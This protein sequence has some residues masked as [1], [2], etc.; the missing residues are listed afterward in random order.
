MSR[1]DTII[2][3]YT[4][5]LVKYKLVVIP[6]PLLRLRTVP[7]KNPAAVAL[8]RLGGKVGGKSRME[9]MSAAQRTEFASRGGKV[10]GKARAQ[11]L[12][13]KRRSE[14]ARKAAVAR[15]AKARGESRK[16]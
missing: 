13:R 12:S 9:Q 6:K 1:L 4:T 2:M 7:K 5:A 14:I 3:H 8:G 15:W 11:K 10:G 16:D